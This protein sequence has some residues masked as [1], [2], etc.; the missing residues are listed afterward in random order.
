VHRTF[1]ERFSYMAIYACKECENEEYI[2]RRF[3][4]HFGPNA[5]CPQCGTFRVVKL[6]APDKIDPRYGGVLDLLER[7][8]GGKLFHCRYCRIQF[9]DRRRTVTESEPSPPAG[10]PTASDAV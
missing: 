3:R 7:V 1:A 10:D 2:P 4:Y 6:K 8:A 5:R 9:H